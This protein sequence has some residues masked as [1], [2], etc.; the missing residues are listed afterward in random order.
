MELKRPNLS[1]TNCILKTTTFIIL[2]N[3]TFSHVVDAIW[4]CCFFYRGV[5]CK[6]FGAV[7]CMGRK[8]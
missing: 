7:R 5:V 3:S 1:T 6:A 2:L 4:L 8:I